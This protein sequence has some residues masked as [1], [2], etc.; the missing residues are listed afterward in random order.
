MYLNR[1]FKFYIKYISW[2]SHKLLCLQKVCDKN[3]RDKNKKLRAFH[4][5]LLK[6]VNAEGHHCKKKGRTVLSLGILNLYSL[7]VLI[8]LLIS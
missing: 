3:E 6:E 2:G 1:I 7:K 5:R 4:I 8:I